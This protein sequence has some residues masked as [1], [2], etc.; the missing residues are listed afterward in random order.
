MTAPGGG[1]INVGSSPTIWVQIRVAN[2]VLLTFG[3][4][5]TPQVAGVPFQVTL[6]SVDAQGA[7]VPSFAG[8]VQ[9]SST[10]GAV[11]PTKVTLASGQWTGDVTIAQPTS[12]VSLLAWRS[13]V[14]AQSETFTVSGTTKEVAVSVTV[15]D[16]SGK[17]S[18]AT[19]TVGGQILPTLTD[20]RGIAVGTVMCAQNVLFEA[21]SGSLTANATEFVRCDGPISLSLSLSGSA[22]NPSGKTPV[23]LLPGILGSTTGK[24]LAVPTLPRDLAVVGSSYTD[25]GG[26]PWH[27]LQSVYG[28]FDPLFLWESKRVGWWPL[29]ESLE[30][31]GYRVGC[32]LFPA[33]YDWR[34]PVNQIVSFYLSQVVQDARRLSGSKK[35]DIIAHSMGGLVARAYIQDSRRFATDQ[36]V[37]VGKLAMLGTPNL[38][39][40]KAY[41]L[42]QGGDV[43]A[44]DGDVGSSLYR[45]TIQYLWEQDQGIGASL[46]TSGPIPLSKGQIKEYSSNES[47]IRSTTAADVSFPAEFR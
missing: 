16:W 9:L 28:L 6:R 4:I 18:G 13:V 23:I 15:L 12:Q 20:A 31:D 10:I 8:E 26:R 35:V 45:D 32:T 29:I 7:V 2:G 17:V 33:P 42:W 11:T 14:S 5:A 3:P 36:D 19:V 39:A 40:V 22:C 44:A 46:T 21:A 24:R 1:T 38:G 25:W 34:L 27:I 41:Y 43:V 37:D 30:H 47:E